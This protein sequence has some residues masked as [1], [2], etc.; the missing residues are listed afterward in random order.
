MWMDGLGVA[1]K[2]LREGELGYG[3]WSLLEGEP[4]MAMES[5]VDGRHTTPQVF[6]GEGERGYGYKGFAG[7]GNMPR[8][9]FYF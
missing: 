5:L 1:I 2:A 9:L 8:V 3:H 6:A 7:E 4:G